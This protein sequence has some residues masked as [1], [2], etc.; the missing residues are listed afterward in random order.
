[1][2]VLPVLVVVLG[3]LEVHLLCEEVFEEEVHKLAVLLL[4]EVVVGEHGHTAT[5]YQ[6]PSAFL[7][8]VDCANGSVAW[9]GKG[10]RCE[11]SIAGILY[12]ERGTV[13]VDEIDSS[14][15]GLL[16]VLLLV[17]IPVAHHEGVVVAALGF[18]GIAVDDPGDFFIEDAV[19]NIGFFGVEIFVE[20][21]TDDAVGVDGDA[22]FFGNFCNV[23]VVPR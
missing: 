12:V 19:V 13:D 16:L 6:L 14:S 18:L 11:D 2:D 23:G 1:M 8:L 22:E 15:L 4:L 21:S 7:V 20:G 5:D 9:I 17:F 3:E 10:S